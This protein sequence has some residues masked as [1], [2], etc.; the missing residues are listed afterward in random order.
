MDKKKPAFHDLKGAQQVRFGEL[1]GFGTVVKQAPIITPEEEDRLWE[2]KVMGDH[3][4]LRAVFIYV[5]KSFCFRGG[6]EGTA[7]Y[8]V[9]PAS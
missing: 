7:Q 9:L 5:G 1:Q 8:Q 4:P 3:S 6:K 2:T